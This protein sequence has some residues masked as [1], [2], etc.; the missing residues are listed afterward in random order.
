MTVGHAVRFTVLLCLWISEARA[1]EPTADAGS[2]DTA[3]PSTPVLVPEEPSVVLTPASGSLVLGVDQETEIKIVV[4]G[5]SMPLDPPRMLCSTGRI[6][7][8]T[9]VG[10]DAFVARYLLPTQ[11]YPQAAIIVAEFLPQGRP[12][13]RGSLV[14]RLR[15]AASPGFRTDPGASVTLKIGDKEFGPQKA[16]ND[17]MVRLPVVVPPGVGFGVARSVNEY[18]KATLQTIDLRIPAYRRVLLVAPETISAGAVVEASVYAVDPSGVP[19][20]N[21]TLVL[22]VSEGKAQPLGG[23]AGEMR[24]LLRAP[25][26]VRAGPLRMTAML[27]DQQTPT[28]SVD[29]PLVAAPAAKLVMTPDR[30]RLPIGAQSS[31]RVYIHAEDGFGNPIDAGPARV[32]V[33]GTITETRSSDDGR[34]MI[35]VPAPAEYDGRDR[36]DL[37]AALGRAYAS[38]SISLAGVPVFRAL[39]KAAQ[40]PQSRFTL[41]PRLGVAWNLIAPPGASALFEFIGRRRSWPASLSAGVAT[42]YLVHSFTA[43]NRMGLSNVTVH[44]VPVL[45]MVRARHRIHPLMALA[46]TLG[47]GA[48]WATTEIRT[49]PFSTFGNKVVPTGE[50][51]A[52]V[53]TLLKRT[54]VLVTGVRYRLVSLGLVSSGDIIEG[55]VAGLIVDIGYRLSW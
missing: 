17:G 14:L 24:F 53:E 43:E 45:A 49:Y 13:L 52:E 36:L 42:G 55:N 19:A 7:E 21:R 18:G 20:D 12:A 50:L 11:R 35:M 15:A 23:P 27:R 39:T 46:S 8:L 44:Q 33:D 54:H 28:M 40:L 1:Q 34:V 41:T 38:Q 47:V 2:A 22:R 30:S 6:E 37:E 29:V 5:V 3:T 26:S 32:T 16:A 9:A 31:M 4:T 51:A 25:P 10:P 48:T